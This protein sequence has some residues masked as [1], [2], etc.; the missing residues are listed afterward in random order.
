[1]RDWLTTVVSYAV[2]AGIP[3]CIICMR[4]I[5]RRRSFVN[6]MA[7][8]I[9]RHRNDDDAVRRHVRRMNRYLATAAAIRR[10]EIVP[11]QRA[12]ALELRARW[13]SA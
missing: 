10:R 1:M 13:F 2:I 4:N 12:Q 8:Q 3:K 5:R 9:Y 7:I 11:P 6:E